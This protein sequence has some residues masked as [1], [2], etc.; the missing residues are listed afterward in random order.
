MSY[1]CYTHP[2]QKLDHTFSKH[3]NFLTWVAHN[4]NIFWMKT[5]VRVPSF[6]PALYNTGFWP[7]TLQVIQQDGACSLSISGPCYCQRIGP[8]IFKTPDTAHAPISNLAINWPLK[9]YFNISM[10]IIGLK[11]WLPTSCTS[12]G[13]VVLALVLQNMIEQAFLRLRHANN[14]CAVLP[15]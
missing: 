3:L 10:N 2:D 9:F 4:P 8:E 12:F 1:W 15:M 13:N 6:V 7:L 14:C 11:A 5:I